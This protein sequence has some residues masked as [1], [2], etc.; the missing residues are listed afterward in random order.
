MVSQSGSPSHNSGARTFAE[1]LEDKSLLESEK[2]KIRGEATLASCAAVLVQRGDQDTAIMLLDVIDLAVEREWDSDGD[3]LWLEIA[4]EHRAQ[5]TDEVMT[6]VR[7]ICSEVSNRHS[8]GIT[9]VG[10]REILPDVGPQWRDRIKQQVSGER[11]TNQARR[12]RSGPSR[13]VEDWLSFTNEGELRVYQ[14]LKRFQEK[15]LPP[16]NTIGIYPLASGRMPGR[17]WEPDI[18]ITYKGRAGIL[19]ID[20]PSHNGRRAL[21]QTRDHVLYDTGIAFVG[22]VPVEALNDPDEL[23]AILRRFLHR[24]EESR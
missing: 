21:D 20:G 5:F 7:E 13:Y 2:Q 10:V 18:L 22:R 4:P 8:Y 23:N 1:I 11:P 17:T 3:D 6:R 12:V 24:L 9:W 14:A 16:E 15:E 19:E